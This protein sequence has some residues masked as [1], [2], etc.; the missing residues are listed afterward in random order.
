MALKQDGVHFPLC[1]KHNQIEGGV[2]NQLCIL[3]I[4]GSYTRV[5]VFGTLNERNQYDGVRSQVK[6]Y[7]KCFESWL[8]VLFPCLA[9]VEFVDEALSFLMCHSLTHNLLPAFVDAY[10]YSFF[11]RCILMRK[12]LPSTAVIAL[13]LC[14]CLSPQPKPI[15]HQPPLPR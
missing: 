14:P 13:S 9:F 10:K 2:L 3:G 6:A 1:P 12:S 15:C 7:L 4:F 8:A 5:K 11:P